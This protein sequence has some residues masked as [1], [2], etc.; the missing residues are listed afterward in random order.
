MPS[1]VPPGMASTPVAV[2]NDVQV[3]ASVE[4]A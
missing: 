3:V 4:E 1:N 2:A